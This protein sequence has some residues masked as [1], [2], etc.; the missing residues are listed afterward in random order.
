MEQEAKN[1]RISELINHGIA[2]DLEEIAIWKK[3]NIRNSKFAL[4]N[5]H[6]ASESLSALIKIKTKLT[7][8]V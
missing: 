3:I 7:D 4:L 5:V 1:S 2:L 6:S 8:R